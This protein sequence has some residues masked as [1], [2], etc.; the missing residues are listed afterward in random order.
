MHLPAS[1]C[2]CARSSDDHERRSDETS[3]HEDSEEHRKSGEDYEDEIVSIDRNQSNIRE[4]SS[5]FYREEERRSELNSPRRELKEK[6]TLKTVSGS[7]EA[8]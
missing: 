1:L 4:H 2:A 3:P 5:F 7:F 6:L 8:G